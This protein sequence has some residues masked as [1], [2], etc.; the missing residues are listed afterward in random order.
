MYDLVARH[1]LATV[2]PDAMY[3]LQT[4]RVVA[5][6][7]TSASR[8]RLAGARGPSGAVADPGHRDDTSATSSSASGDGGIAAASSQGLLGEH[9]S[10]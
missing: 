5:P 7:S 10:A 9:F 4:L 6:K 3:E 1:F 2:S 8:S